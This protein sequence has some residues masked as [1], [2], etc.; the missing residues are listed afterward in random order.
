MFANV[1]TYKV[2]QNKRTIQPLN[3]VNSP[4]YSAPPCTNYKTT[5]SRRPPMLEKKLGY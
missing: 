4:V 3:R 2:A 5:T 1:Y